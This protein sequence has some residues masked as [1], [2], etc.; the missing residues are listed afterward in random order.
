MSKLSCGISIPG[1]KEQHGRYYKII[2]NKWHPLTRVSDGI[3]ALYRALQELDP[4]KPGTIGELIALYRAQGMGHLRPATAEDYE[5][6]LRRLEVGFGGAKID[7]LRPNQV[8]NYLER[9][10]KAGK[11]ATRANRE[12]AVLSAVH[13]FGMRNLY[14]EYNPVKGTDR[15]TE[16]PKKR[17][18]TDSQFLDAFNRANE[19]FQDL[20]G[21]AYLTGVR[22][23]DLIAWRRS[24][25]LTPDG[26][27]YVQSKTGKRH[28]VKWSDAVRF[29]MRRAMERNTDS[30]L[31]LLNTRGEPWTVSGIASQ[32]QRLG[33]EWSF[34]DLRAKAQTDSAHSVLGHGA[35]LEAMYRKVLRTSPVR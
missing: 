1:V 35:A 27:D 3:N 25:H 2:G 17:Y 13:K 6:I 31:V 30:D 22:Q 5:N 14:C 4:F 28:L 33:V 24:V 19:P 9:R 29:L 7:T 15:N 26:I 16:S 21:L 20:I 12:V 18:V 34:K 32:L 23:T 11:G 10:K 8:S